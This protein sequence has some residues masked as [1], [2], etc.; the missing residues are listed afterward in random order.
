MRYSIACGSTMITLIKGGY[1]EATEP[2]VKLSHHFK[3]IMV[4]IMTLLT[5]TKYMSQILLYINR[6]FTMEF[7][8]VYGV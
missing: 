2:R 5:V 3:K 4:L 8:L 1:K 7:G 6:K